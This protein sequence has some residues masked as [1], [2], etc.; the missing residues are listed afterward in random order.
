MQ[1][2]SI[3]CLLE[4][5]N[6]FSLRHPPLN[7][8]L[9]VQVFNMRS[10]AD[11]WR[12]YTLWRSGRISWYFVPGWEQINVLCI[13]PDKTWPIIIFFHCSRYCHF[14]GQSPFIPF[15]F[16]MNSSHSFSVLWI[17]TAYTKSEVMPQTQR[18]GN[19]WEFKFTA[20]LYPK[21]LGQ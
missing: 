6:G 20:T 10:L 4:E 12:S 13:F 1:G 17:L 21:A 19:A 7:V 18:A 9:L 11:S 14:S 16:S 15:T 8:P 5:R 2:Q 3:G